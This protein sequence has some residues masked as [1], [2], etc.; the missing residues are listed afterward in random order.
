MAEKPVIRVGHIR[1]TDHLVLGVA[2]ELFDNGDNRLRHLSLE[3]VPMVG[4]QEVANG[5]AKGR[6]DAACVL[7]PTAM[8]LFKAGV[9]LR[10]ALLTHKTGSIFIKNKSAGLESFED[11]RHKVVIIPYQ[12]S[13]HNMLLHRLL[14]EV[15]LNPG[16]GKDAGVDVLL[17]V[18]APAMMPQAIQYDDDGEIAGFI[19]AEPF[20]SQVISE[21][22]GEEL[23][24]SKDLWPG[25][26]CCVF[27]VRDETINRHGDAVYELTEALVKAGHYIEENP[28]ASAEIGSRFLDQ[29][30]SVIKRV[31]TEP[32]DRIA[33]GELLPVLEDLETMQNYMHDKMKL[34]KSKIDLEE[35]V[36]TAYAKAAGAK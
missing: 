21:G 8:D 33:T 17:E 34:L 29:E 28:N 14:T 3:T 16:T 11:F 26:P 12:L 27:V 5:L 23:Y 31:L 6:I 30:V 20:G 18:M 24:L 4:W 15:G 13:I 9:G 25:H 32:A 10:L 7:A 35:F 22:Y 1:I 36:D 19:V 2:K